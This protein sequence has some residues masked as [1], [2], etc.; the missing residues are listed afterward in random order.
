MTVGLTFFGGCCCPD[1]KGGIENG[2]TRSRLA[3]FVGNRLCAIFLIELVVSIAALVVGLLSALSVVA[4]PAAAGYA[5]LG[6]GAFILAI[7]LLAIV[8]II[9]KARAK[10]T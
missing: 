8:V 5:L 3:Q 2:C 6:V 9:A 10:P 1:D 7:D 4:M